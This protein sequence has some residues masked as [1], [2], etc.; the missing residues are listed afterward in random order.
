M[1]DY[2]PDDGY[3][4]SSEKGVYMITRKIAS[5]FV[6]A[7]SDSPVVLLHGAR[8]TGKSTLIKYLIKNKHHADYVTLDDSAVLSAAINNPE[9]FI[10]S[11]EGNVAIDEVQR[12]PELFLSIKKNID[13]QRKPGK[14]ILAGSANVLLLPKIS[15][16]LAG[17]I[18]LLTLYP[19]AQNEIAKSNFNLIN[20]LFD[21]KL[22]R[23]EIPNSNIE[24]IKK[25]VY[26]GYPEIQDRKNE[27]RRN[28][29]FKSYITTILQR[30]V[31]DIS[32][33]EGLTQLPRLLSLMGA[34]VGSLLNSTEFSR[35]AG[36]P[37]TTLKRYINLLEST[38]MIYLLPAYSGNLSKRLIKT[39]KIYLYDTGLLSHLI[40]ADEKRLRNDPHLLGSII[41]NFVLMELIKQASWSNSVFNFFH[42]RTS[43]G[44]E[45]DFVIE[46]NDGTLI[47]IE[48]K[49]AHSPRAEM[50]KG[51]KVLSE[52]TGKNFFKGFLFYNGD[53]LI[54]FDKNLFAIPIKYLWI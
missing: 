48:V 24:I 14:F 31:R 52:E 25:I 34:R 16:S 18:E 33:I 4:Q 11:F 45:V 26:G 43:S 36:I 10:E 42:F 9:S 30:D 41:E 6:S 8:Q 5:K 37:Q 44:Q 39:P 51:L 46:R 2:P 40:S 47:G 7:L 20:S 1:V 32:N 28:A 54:Q 19:F 38:F 49:A 35:S 17:R 13:K 22:K 23:L 15:E 53:S 29:W 27:E 50:F 12:A 21:K 3:I